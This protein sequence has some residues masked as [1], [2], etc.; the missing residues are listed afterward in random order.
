[1]RPEEDIDGEADGRLSTPLLE[2]RP[3]AAAEQQS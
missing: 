3:A 1:M 2:A